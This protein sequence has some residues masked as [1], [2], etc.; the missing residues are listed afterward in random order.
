MA[1]K[2]RYQ[3]HTTIP[4][5][6][7]S[8]SSSCITQGSVPPSL[9]HNPSSCPTSLPG[10][11]HRLARKS[12][13]YGSR[14]SNCNNGFSR[15]PASL[16]HWEILPTQFPLQGSSLPQGNPRRIGNIIPCRIHKVHK[17]HGYNG[18]PKLTPNIPKPK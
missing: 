5:N 2:P 1:S 4:T 12:Q 10:L 3:T 15:H 7:L 17:K 6:I 14:N 13:S 11:K 18:F 8:F 16:T 9:H